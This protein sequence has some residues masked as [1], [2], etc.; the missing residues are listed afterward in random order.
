MHITDSFLKDLIIRHEFL[1][2]GKLKSLC[3]LQ[4]KLQ[5]NK[6]P[7]TLV[8]IFQYKKVFSEN[9]LSQLQQLIEFFNTRTY[10]SLLSQFAIEENMVS[11]EQ[12]EK[13][14]ITQRAI[15]EVNNK[16]VPLAKIFEIKEVCNEKQLQPIIDKI[17]ALPQEKLDKLWQKHQTEI[18][19]QDK[20]DLKWRKNHGK[21]K[22]MASNKVEKDAPSKRQA[23]PSKLEKDTPPSK[24]EKDTP[25]SKLQAPPSKLEKDTPP[26]KLQAPPS[27]LEKDTPHEEPTTFSIE[28][29]SAAKQPQ[30]P[31][32][33]LEEDE[34]ASPDLA[35]DETIPPSKIVV[36]DP[37][38]HKKSPPVK[39]GNNLALTSFA[40]A[41]VILA[42]IAGVFYFNQSTDEKDFA[43]ISQ[44]MERQENAEVE[45]KSRLFLQRYP[46]SNL[47]DKVKENLQD[48]LVRKAQIFF[49][50]QEISQASTSLDEAA[51]LGDFATKRIA[52]LRR[53]IYN[54][55]QLALRKSNFKDALQ[56][57]Q[58]MMKNND[59]QRSQTFITN[60]ANQYKEDWAK[61]DLQKLRSY[62]ANYKQ[63]FIAQTY[64]YVDTLPK[65]KGVTFPE[66]SK[67]I[68]LEMLP[69]GEINASK[70][71]SSGTNFFAIAKN[72]LYCFDGQNG[73]IRWVTKTINNSIHPVFL[74]GPKQNFNMKIADRVLL[75]QN[76]NLLVMLKTSDGSVIWK[77]KIPGV[78]STQPFIYKQRIYVG[79]FND[80]C[81]EIDVQ[82]GNLLGAYR[83]GE[84]PLFAPTVD[85]KL[86]YMFIPC[87]DNVYVYNKDTGKL[88]YLIPYDKTPCA[89]TIAVFPYLCTFTKDKTHSYVN[90]YKI[91]KQNSQ[92]LKTVSIPG[93]MSTPA[94]MS[95]GNL[96]IA[97]NKYLQLFSLNT[98]NV[99]EAIF[100]L[101][102]TSPILLDTTQTFMQFSNLGRSLTVSS[103]KL[104]AVDI[105][106]FT[107]RIDVVRKKWEL[108]YSQQNIP[109]PI[110]RTREMIFTVTAKQNNYTA[111]CFAYKE[112]TP[113]KLWER[114]FASSCYDSVLQLNDGR[115]YLTTTEGSIHEIFTKQ[116]K[117][118]YRVLA[119][120][121]AFA[122]PITIDN[123]H[124]FTIDRENHAVLCNNITGW[125]VWKADKINAQKYLGACTGE[126]AIFFA[127]DKTI[128]ALNI[129]T[130]KKSHLEYSEFKGK[131][132]SSAP[133]F[134][135]KSI[136]IGSEDGV[137]ELTLA[138]QD[139]IAFLQKKWS[140][141]AQNAVT[142][143]PIC[144]KDTLYF[145]SADGNMYAI[146]FTRRRLKW[147]AKTTGAIHCRP[148]IHNN[149]IY[150]GND[151]RQIYAVNDEGK[152]L[153][154]K[155]MTGK[156]I[157]SPAV[158][159]ERIYFTSVAGEVVAITPQGKT[160]WRV[161]IPGT[162]STSPI[163][164]GNFIAIAS[165]NGFVYFVK[166]K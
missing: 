106:L 70:L 59:L 54:Y 92:L 151:D 117:I 122:P 3:E 77:A 82:N 154:R 114:S 28:K 30:I 137:H 33:K 14:L 127:Y 4:K 120:D 158:I 22:S 156:I 118:N 95:C 60:I 25:P 39:E 112:G 24:L 73:R 130:G 79:L 34:A 43:I 162:I 49:N 21:D 42:V 57:A 148:T 83:T 133:Y 126:N 99:Q 58:N 132:F 16:V 15:F 13:S 37:S 76:P 9:R 40:I 38:S 18:N 123:E 105:Q 166:E 19:K 143:T 55:Q 140:F 78:V 135:N 164:I 136:F 10:D 146:D 72:H 8:E 17:K 74:A 75:L 80:H 62:F 100:P 163:K 84:T 161:F 50:Q 144:V 48:I 85:R 63:K 98:K 159:D 145:G 89:P 61:R 20:Q 147:N 119:T 46:D 160:L 125:P 109:M 2:Q 101:N 116:N 90:L 47:G 104:F 91:G 155:K 139:D 29:T 66:N 108:D 152:T 69:L 51:Q 138:K 107:K 157:A 115:T 45:K 1:Q 121:T 87:H 102:K 6:L 32:S 68:A 131:S 67:N 81:L 12:Y 93:E 7:K 128:T 41:I 124:F 11:Q 88:A 113:V 149:T 53:E 165:N 65:Y 35:K 97:T 86:N 94:A 56:Q 103:Q 36:I 142:T 96:A 44:L 31:P 153:W 110:Q 134:Y 141:A 27:K 26:S 150:F 64:V 111:H 129:T 52:N 23:P 5:D 71:P